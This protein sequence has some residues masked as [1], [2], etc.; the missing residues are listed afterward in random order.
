MILPNI[1]RINPLIP[2]TN[3]IQTAADILNREGVVVV[4]TDTRYGLAVRA[5]M[6]D[7][8]RKVYDIKGRNAKNPSA[9]FIKDVECISDHAVETDISKRLAARFLPGPMTL[10]LRAREDRAHPAAYEGKIGLR[11]SSSKVI[12]D[13]L[14]SVSFDL[15]ATSANR[16]GLADAETVKEIAE[17]FGEEVDLYLDAG[18]LDGPV[19]TVVDC[20]GDKAVILREGAISH[21]DI[22][23]EVPV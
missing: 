2:E 19:S 18:F 11:I 16:S 12:S 20:S 4:P 14:S 13:L 10:V 6:A 8:M 17:E 3:I 22:A 7:V 1:L 15:T 9:I 23:Q 21:E 5:D